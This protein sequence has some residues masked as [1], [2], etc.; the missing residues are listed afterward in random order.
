[1]FAIAS[2]CGVLAAMNNENTFCTVPFGPLA[3]SVKNPLN[4]NDGVPERTPLALRDN[5]DG[6]PPE[7]NVQ[8]HGEPQA[9]AVSASL[10]GVPTIAGRRTPAVSMAN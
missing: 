5:P 8:A 1:M 2:G 4:W 3:R 9:A 6:G 10:Y 7:T